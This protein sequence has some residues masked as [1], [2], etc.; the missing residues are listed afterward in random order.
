MKL[1]KG[2]GFHVQK[3]VFEC[4]LSDAQVQKLGELLLKRIDEKTDSVR[5]YQLCNGCSENT[6]VLGLGEVSE[7]PD[8]AV[9]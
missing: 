9:I 3:S 4:I 1:L 7:V 2:Y 5:I 6:L 8:V